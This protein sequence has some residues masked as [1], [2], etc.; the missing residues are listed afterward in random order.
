MVRAE[1]VSGSKRR[2][3][4]RRRRSKDRCAGAGGR[5]SFFEEWQACQAMGCATLAAVQAAGWAAQ[6]AE[7]AERVA[8]LAGPWDEDLYLG[9]E[10][11]DMYLGEEREDMYLGF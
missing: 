11:E 9:E 5:A 7:A 1:A 6:Q 10:R 8:D 3:V 2:R 4:D